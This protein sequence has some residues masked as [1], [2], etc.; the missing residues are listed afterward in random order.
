MR[1]A[2]A[3]VRGGV[4]GTVRVG[5]MHS[6]ALIELAALLTRYH[7]EHPGMLLAAH[8]IIRRHDAGA[9]PCA[10]STASTSL[11]TR[12]AG[13]PGSAS[14]GSSPKPAC[15]ERDRRRGR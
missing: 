2:V 12:R 11:T 4:R 9:S 1:D 7:R 8:P 15:I 3:A 6:L 13:E 14:I 10:S 5:I